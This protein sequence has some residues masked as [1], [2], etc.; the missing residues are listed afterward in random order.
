MQKLPLKAFALF[1]HQLRM[2][3]VGLLIYIGSSGIIE[4]PRSGSPSPIWQFFFPSHLWISLD[5]KGTWYSHPWDLFRCPSQNQYCS[6]RYFKWSQESK[7]PS[8]QCFL[9][10]LGKMIWRQNIRNHAKI[11]DCKLNTRFKDE[12][13]SEYILVMLRTLRVL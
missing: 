4:E 13:T 5:S 2:R 9:N 8:N 7:W 10:S 12:A 11:D 1:S 3:E 6:V